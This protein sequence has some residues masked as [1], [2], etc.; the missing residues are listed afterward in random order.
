[1]QGDLPQLRCL[2]LF[3][4]LTITISALFSAPLQAISEAAILSSL[5]HPHVVKLTRW[6]KEEVTA[7]SLSSLLQ[8]MIMHRA[9]DKGS[10]GEWSCPD[11][12]RVDGFVDLCAP[13][14]ALVAPGGVEVLCM[15][16]EMCAPWTL[17]SPAGANAEVIAQLRELASGLE[18]IHSRGV[19]HL[20]VKPR[21]YVL[22]RLCVCRLVADGLRGAENVFRG[23]D[24]RLKLGDFGRAVRASP[25]RATR[26]QGEGERGSRVSGRLDGGRH[27][28]G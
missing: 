5:S 4:L 22:H 14:E 28:A 3:R 21:K 10:T 12:E 19:A 15:E 2:R 9:V 16:M 13:G 18:Y 8:P 17:P 6:W 20:D 11:S 1:M 24:G 27:V 25:S 7:D 23:L 26:V